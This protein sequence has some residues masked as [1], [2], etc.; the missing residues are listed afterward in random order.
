[1]EALKKTYLETHAEELLKAA[2]MNK[3]K[4]A[5]QMGVARQNI[6]KLLETKNVITLSKAAAI[7]N[8]PLTT[9]IY[10]YSQQTE[11]SIDGFVEVNGT[12]YRLRNRED[13]ENI[14]S[15]LQDEPED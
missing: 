14:L 15:M 12:I 9:L 10:G 4:F 6:L 5:E 1:M 7:L 2:G 8:V 11:A 13:I 3:A